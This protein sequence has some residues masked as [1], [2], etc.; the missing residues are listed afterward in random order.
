VYLHTFQNDTTRKRAMLA[1][2]FIADPEHW[3]ERAQDMRL[4][5]SSMKDDRAKARMLKIAEG[6]E[7][8]GRQSE[9]R[10]TKQSTWAA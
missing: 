7:A 8:L 2:G 1:L 10:I 4:T 9:E 5:A 3:R 6:Y